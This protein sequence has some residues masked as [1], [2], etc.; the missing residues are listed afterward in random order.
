MMSRIEA[1]T[2]LIEATRVWTD[3]VTTCIE[4]TEINR[5]SLIN[6]SQN[7]SKR[8]TRSSQVDHGS[9][10]LRD[11][12]I[13]QNEA[14]VDFGDDVDGD[15]DDNDVDDYCCWLGR[16]LLTSRRKSTFPIVVWLY[17]SKPRQ[18]TL[19]LTATHNS[20]A[21]GRETVKTSDF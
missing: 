2:H 11:L 1:K 5:I 7:T 18:L 20:N 3:T 12:L 10:F 4:R 9:V 21:P 16:N 6:H 15:A 17:Y 8:W 14:S 13:V 19:H